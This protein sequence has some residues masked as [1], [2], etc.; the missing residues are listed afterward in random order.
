MTERIHSINLH[1]FSNSVLETLNEQRNRGHFC[2]VT[3]RIHGSMLRAHRCVLAAGSPFFQDKLLL[4][5]SDIEIPSVVSVHAVQKLIDFMYSGVLRVSQSEAL[6]ILT[7]ASI[8]QIKTVIDECT[9]I[10]SQNVGGVYPLIQDSG[11]ETPRGTPESGTSGQ[12]SDTES[13]FMR[14]HRQHSVDRIYSALYTC[15]MQ[16]GSGERSFYSGALVSHHETAL[17]LPRQHHMEEPSWITRIHQRSQR[18][19]RF[20]TNTPETTHCRKQPRPVR[21]QTMMGN[22][23]IKQEVDDDYD[24]YGQQRSQALERNESEECTEDTDQAE[25]TESEPKGESF[26]SGVSSSIGTEPD[27]MEQQ[28]MPGLVR[29]GQ[30]DPSQAESNNLSTECVENQNQQ[31]LDTSSSSPERSNTVDMDSTVLSVSNSTEKGVL[32]T[33][34]SQSI[35]QALPTTQLYLRQTE[36]LTSNLRMPLT[37]TSN[38]QV[39][40]TAG[41]TYLPTLFTTQAAGTGP[42]PFLFSLPQP[43]AAQQT[44]FVT[45]PQASLSSFPSQIQNQSSQGGHS[46]GSSQGEKKPYECT[47]CNKTF[48]AKQNYVK[49]MF[50]HTG[51]KPHQCSICWRSFSLK[52]YLIKHMVTHTGVRAYQCSIC[53]KRFTQKSSL[54]VHMRLH[55]GEKSYECYIC[56]KKFSHKTLLERH[57]ALHSA[58]NGTASI[59]VPV[60]PSNSAPG[61]VQAPATTPGQG[62]PPAPSMPPAPVLPPTPVLAS[63][64]VLA[65]TPALVPAPILVSA[66][67]PAPSLAAPP[68]AAPTP[69]PVLVPRPGPPNGATTVCSEGT[70]Y[71]CSVC[72][73]KFDQIEQFNDHMRM[74]VSDG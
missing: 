6:Q 57:V 55:R 56:K 2:D 5:Y 10:V 63:A 22:I 67:A 28:F 42:K 53:N 7:A 16:N 62:L 9:R 11:Q 74:H 38:T 69:S 50:V 27:S 37:L 36:T 35:A 33:S 46:T 45:V 59:P 23:H 64:P 60:P 25:G 58:T 61:S 44:Q 8:L 13:G 4:G 40:G 72:P 14:N 12:S 29:D 24:Y 51:E 26:D 47:L 48:T 21:I 54:N 70:T 39:I 1:N 3:V 20:L 15:S 17:G 19:E 49:H 43:L 52:D 73:A 68:T 41:N 34:V 30:Q 18:M 71:V 66:L 32:Q 65:P 31:H